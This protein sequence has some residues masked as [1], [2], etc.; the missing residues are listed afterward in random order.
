MIY[1]IPAETRYMAQ[2]DWLTSFHLFSFAE[3]YDPVNMHFGALRVFNDDYIDAYN[4]FGEHAHTNM[5]IVTIMLE[6]ELTHAD[7]MGNTGVIRK[8]EIQYMSAGTGVRHS[9][10]NNG[11]ERV[12]LYQLWFLPKKKNLPPR[13]AQKNMI[14]SA[15]DN[16]RLIPLVSDKQIENVPNLVHIESDITLYTSYLET[17]KKLNYIVNKNRGLFIYIE[18]GSLMI[19]GDLFEAGDQARITGEESIEI[20]CMVD[21]SF[22]AIDVVMNL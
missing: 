4:G 8:G 19:N 11:S 1:K 15:Q 14:L 18:K 5:E 12:H 22:I 6:G 2:H 17:D 20:V 16:N 7:S 10:V 9:E 21:S 13:Y 3:Y